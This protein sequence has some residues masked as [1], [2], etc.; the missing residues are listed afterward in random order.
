MSR[1]Y[2]P[3]FLDFNESTQDLTD[4][5][6]GRLVRSIVDYANGRDYESRLTGG[7]KIAFRFLKGT[8]DRNQAISEVRAKAGASRGKKDQMLANVS[9][10]EQ[11]EPNSTN[12]KII[13]KNE[14]QKTNNVIAAKAAS[15]RFIKPTVEEVRAYIAER[16][17]GMTSE[18]AEV[19]VD[20]YESKGW[21]VGSQPMK[22]WKAAVRTWEQRNNNKSSTQT[23]KVVAQ[24]YEQR[25]YSETEPSMEEVLKTLQQNGLLGA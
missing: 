24:Q 5:E 21:K 23:K 3:L 17:K 19:F 2:I 14:E 6:C 16:N 15:A 20:F 9:K 4:E 25:D 1:E 10:N 7:E 12:K 8:I 11:I 22:D 13:T 18:D